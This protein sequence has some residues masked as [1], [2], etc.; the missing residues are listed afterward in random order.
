LDVTEAEL[1]THRKHPG[2]HP[3]SCTGGERP[4]RPP[5]KPDEPKP[6]PTP[7]PPKPE[8]MVICHVFDRYADKDRGRET[9]DLPVPRAEWHLENHGKCREGGDCPGKCKEREK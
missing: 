5:S 2:D 3:G 9:L 4:P 8:R 7:E 6:T 1:E